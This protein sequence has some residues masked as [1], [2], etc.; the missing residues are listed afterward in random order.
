MVTIEAAPFSEM[1][2]YVKS[3]RGRS[4]VFVVDEIDFLDS[5]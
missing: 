3:G 1:V 4:R 2:G 5:W